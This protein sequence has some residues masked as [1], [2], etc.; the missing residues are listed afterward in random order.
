MG[1][2][3]NACN[4]R[5]WSCAGSILCIYKPAIQS[6]F[7]PVFIS[8]IYFSFNFHSTV[9]MGCGHGSYYWTPNCYHHCHSWRSI[10]CQLHFWKTGRS[11]T[12]LS[13]NVRFAFLIIDATTHSTF[14]QVG[15][16]GG[17]LF[18]I[19]AVAT[20]FGVFWQSPDRTISSSSTPYGQADA[21]E[22]LTLGA[23]E[24][25]G[26][27]WLNVGY[28]IFLWKVY[29]IILFITHKLHNYDFRVLLV[30]IFFSFPNGC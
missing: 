26:R 28:W 22:D 3:L 11:L 5:S 23:T 21:F 7:F 2:S 9:S 4:H 6:L 25:R 10:S 8:I 1:W 20:F 13:Y 24:R 18:L 17:A 16:L 27:K 29:H 30:N 19:F 12:S 14:N 15:Y